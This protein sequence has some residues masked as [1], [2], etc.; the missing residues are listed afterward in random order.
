MRG[1]IE[2]APDPNDARIFLYKPSAEFLKYCGLASID[3]LP[4]Y[5]LLAELKNKELAAMEKEGQEQENA[6]T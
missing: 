2:R 5:T 4:E 1:L 3:E 6:K